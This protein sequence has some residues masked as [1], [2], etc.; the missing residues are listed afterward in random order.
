MEEIQKLLPEFRENLRKE[1]EAGGYDLLVM[2]FTDVMGEGSMFVYEGPLSYV[3]NDIL[4][5][6]FDEHS[7]YD[8]KII[9]RKQQLMPK[10]SEIIKAL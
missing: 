2:L 7:G 8:T 4:E 6:V 1:Q 3:F 9:S 5:T 10:L